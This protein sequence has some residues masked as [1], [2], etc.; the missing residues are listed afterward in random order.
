MAN[1][2]AREFVGFREKVNQD[3]LWQ[4]E[5]QKIMGYAWVH[6]NGHQRSILQIAE[7]STMP[8][9]EEKAYANEAIARAIIANYNENHQ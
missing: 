3:K 2:T 1:A 5:L 6:G 8:E 7:A 9:A 4:I